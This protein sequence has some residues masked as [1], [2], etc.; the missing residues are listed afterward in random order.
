[1]AARREKYLARTVAAVQEALTVPHEIIVVFDGSEARCKGAPP[2]SAT[3]VQPWEDARGC[4]ACRDAGAMLAKG[5]TLVMVDAH[6][7]WPGGLDAAV[8]QATTGGGLCCL[9]CSGLDPATW[10]QPP[11][12]PQTHGATILELTREEGQPITALAPKYLYGDIAEPMPVTC[13]MGAT[14]I[15]PTALY[16]DTMRRPLQF[17]VGWGCDEQILSVVAH[18]LGL[19]VTVLPHL[20]LHW[21]RSPNDLGYRHSPEDI[22]NLWRQQRRMLAQLPMSGSLRSKLARAIAENGRYRDAA[23]RIETDDGLA[24]V[25][26]WRDS[27]P[28]VSNVDGMIAEGLILADGTPPPVRPA[29]LPKTTQTITPA[30][31]VPPPKPEPRPNGAPLPTKQEAPPADCPHCHAARGYRVLNT[32]PNGNRRV[33]CAACGL[34]FILFPHVVAKS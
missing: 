2:K 20:A 15:L 27:M 19:P 33:S 13:V 25:S 24:A 14:Y 23:G 31:E 10:T 28:W 9:C 29:G 32:Y 18:C 34:P 26:Q 21:Y 30:D 17:G 22:D 12:Q 5:D 8:A 7:A 16:R 4:A 1:M 3:C 11:G 6:M